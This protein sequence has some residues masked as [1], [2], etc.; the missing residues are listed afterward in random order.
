MTNETRAKGGLPK[1]EPM[2]IYIKIYKH[3]KR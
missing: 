2:T 3:I 1:D